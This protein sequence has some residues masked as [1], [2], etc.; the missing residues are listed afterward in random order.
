MATFQYTAMDGSGKEQKG[1]IEADNQQDAAAKLKQKGLFAT[2]ISE[3]KAASKDGKSKKKKSSG[4]KSSKKQI[5]L[6]TPVIKRKKLMNFT[7]QLATL[8]NAGQAL[9]RALRTLERQARKDAATKMIVGEL[10][11]AVEGGSTFSEALSG[12][13]KTFSKLYVSMVRAGEAAGQLEDTL[14][15]LAL[16]MEKAERV[17]GRIKSAM[18]YPIVVM[19]IA[20]GITVLLM[21]FIVPRFSN[22]FDDMLSGEPL[23]ALT[24]Y[25]IAASEFMKNHFLIFIGIV[26]G[27]IVLLK[28]SRK[29]KKG[30][31]VFDFIGIKLPPI[32]QL[33]VRSATARVCRTLGTLMD[34]GVSVLQALQIAR[35]TS[36]NELI[37][38]SMQNVH[39]AVKEGE[40]MSQPLQN[41]GVFP[42]I[43]IS[44][45][46]VG[47]ETGALPS[48]FTRIADVYDEEVDRAVDSLTS[49]ME[50]VMIVFLAAVVGTIVLAM[51]LPLV[52]L[53][54]TLGG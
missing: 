1:S 6:T 11:D 54:Q 40:N 47:E 39:D 8:L 51:F 10:A 52:K 16:F 27:L 15:N 45:V 2:S 34:S 23:P 41:A 3:S 48:M 49:M 12:H 32:N 18:T 35:D 53:I 7:R 14:N 42:P 21:V 31:L 36:G 44:M 25:V 13:P 29:T 38:R 46:E 20:L 30:S 24:N 5:M 4:S 33:V 22:I 9:V 50:P 43:V 28:I 26:V 17:R 37:A 19:S